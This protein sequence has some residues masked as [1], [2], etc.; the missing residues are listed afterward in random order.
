MDLLTIFLTALILLFTLF[1]FFTL[2]SLR[3]HAQSVTGSVAILIPMRNEERNVAGVIESALSQAHIKD[4][5][6]KVIDD[7]SIDQTA[8]I[9]AKLGDSRLE[10][11][12][13]H[14]PPPGWLGKNF[15]LQTLAESC[16]QEYLVFLDADVRLHKSAIASA[17]KILNERD[18]D[19]IC[20]YPRQIAEGFLARL[21]QPLLQW[22]WMASL[23]L[24]LIEDS[25]LAATVVANGQF[26]VVRNESYKRAGG[27]AG[28]RGEVLDDMELARALRRSGS[29]GSVVNGATMASCEMYDS[30]RELV[31]GY[32][33][34]Q[35]R[36]FGNPLGALTAV[37]LLALTSIYPFV[38]ILNGEPWAIYAIT[39]ILLSRLLVAIK[40]ESVL[41][42]T[43]LHPIAI[44]TWIFLIFRSLHLKRKNKLVWR[45][46]AI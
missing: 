1:N 13:G 27:H 28:V 38:A 34:S 17:I 10:V 40:T 14:E 3:H 20:P 5:S 16:D 37:F 24:R 15:A 36:A 22:S 7:C 46:R 39:A 30:A 18:W 41:S 21:V 45:A 35:W 2:R 32:S 33:K 23:P 9:L 31:D 42:T 44:A 11:S 43:L 4:L 26:F 6:I 19:Y 8:S 25:A 29:R 12:T